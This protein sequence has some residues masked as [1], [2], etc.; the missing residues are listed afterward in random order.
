MPYWMEEPVIKKKTKTATWESHFANNKFYTE[1]HKTK[2]T[3]TT[4]QRLLAQIKEMVNTRTHRSKLKIK[5]ILLS[6][7]SSRSNKIVDEIDD[8]T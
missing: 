4:S 8:L 5:S 6:W 2:F 7:N 3:L 1:N